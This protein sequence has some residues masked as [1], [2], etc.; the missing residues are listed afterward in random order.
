MRWTTADAARTRCDRGAAEAA[1]PAYWGAW[2]RLREILRSN[3]AA[4][5]ALED[6][7]ALVELDG[8]ERARF[9]YPGVTYTYDPELQVV[10]EDRPGMQAAYTA[11]GT[12]AYAT[13]TAE[14]VEPLALALA[15]PV[16]PGAEST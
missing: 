4:H 7:P 15:L 11:R 14:G 8:R 5:D 10:I 9:L 16:P 1:P 2:S 13:A 3:G 6:E 12:I